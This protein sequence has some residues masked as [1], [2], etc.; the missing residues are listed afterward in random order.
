MDLKRL[1]STFAYRIEPKPEGGFIAHAT[2]PAVPPLEAAT[3]LELQQKIQQTILTSLSTQF[4]GLKLPPEG[5]HIEMAFHIEHKPEG[6]FAIHSSDPNTPVIEAGSQQEIESR[7]LEKFLGFA[8]KHLM[9]ELAQALAAQG[10]TGDVKIVVNHRIGFTVNSPTLNLGSLKSLQLPT[11]TQ[12]NQAG[13]TTL[14]GAPETQTADLGTIGGTLENA[15]ITPEPSNIG[16]VFRLVI[17]L[18][19]V[20]AML[21]FILRYR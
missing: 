11:S 12:L 1:I 6:G 10:N 14:N 21:Y 8:G 18:L 5:K 13:T 19:I 9:P 3:R 15:P 2:D 17:A 16:K 7:F 4:P 20:G